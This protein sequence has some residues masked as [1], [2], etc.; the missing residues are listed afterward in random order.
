MKLGILS[1]THN[2]IQNIQLA[3]KIFEKHQVT[4]LLHCGDV[5]S[6]ATL[7]WLVEY[8][9]ILTFGN[10]DVATGEMRA[11]LKGCSISNEAQYQYEC[12]LN[13]KRI[14][15]SHGHLPEINDSILKQQD[16]DYFFHGHTHEKVDR[17]VG[18][19]R[20]INPGAVVQMGNYPSSVCIF[21][22]EKGT[23]VFEDL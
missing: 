8:P 7:Q 12:N 3:L 22:P 11:Y 9:L 6:L 5:T 2:D 15:A 20:V 1:D 4:S 10:G 17:W 13:G 18:R 14:A 21:E 16:I 19:T 23:I